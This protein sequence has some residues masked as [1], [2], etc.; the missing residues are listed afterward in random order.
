[1]K[2]YQKALE[3]FTEES[4]I[5]DIECMD[6]YTKMVYYKALYEL[7]ELEGKIYAQ[8]RNKQVYEDR[9]ELMLPEFEKLS[10]EANAKFDEIL[11]EAIKVGKGNPNN[12]YSNTIGMILQGWNSMKDQKLDSATLQELKNETYKSLKTQIAAVQEKQN[13]MRKA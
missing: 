3:D 11:E 8:E 6:T 1:M 7:N 4:T 13:G 12:R 5:E 10:A 2:D 9:I